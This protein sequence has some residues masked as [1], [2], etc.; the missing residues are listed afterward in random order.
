[1]SKSSRR[2]FLRR[3]SLGALGLAAADRLAPL[4][5]GAP[6]GVARAAGEKA[7]VVINLFGGNDG[8]NTV[9]PLGQYDRYRQMR[10]TLA[11]DRDELVALPGEPDFALNPGLAALA[12]LYA[13]GRL[14]LLN[15]VGVPPTATG[16]FDHA[17]QQFEFQSCDVVRAGGPGAPTGWLGRYLD[18]HVG[19]PVAPGIDMGGGRL[20]LTGSA[21]DPLSVNT[22][23]DLALRIS[24]DETARHDAYAAVQATPSANPVAERHRQ[25]RLQ[26]LDQSDRILAAVAGYSPRAAY[27]ADSSL[28]FY[29]QQCAKILWGDLGVR[30]LCVGLGGFDTHADQDDGRDAASL[31]YHAG[32][33]KDLADSMAAFQADVEAHGL[34]DRVLVLTVSEFGRTPFENG[35]AGSDHGF[36][37]VAFA[38]GSAVNGGVYG[39]YPG[40]GDDDLVLDGNVDVTT[41]FRSVYATAVGNFLGADPV[42]AV[43]GS[44]P[45]LG[46]V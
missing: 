32:L 4:V 1:M 26:A 27:P 2:S 35:S 40:L 12:P 31:G 11:Y 34:A 9:V 5:S 37:S 39:T 8:L 36:G 38:L 23:E 16:L 22:I 43:G 46:Y 17:A 14:A 15:G 18:A 41:D 33:L 21:C 42:P 24:F 44:F 25:V 7:V 19:G 30:G 20:M 45:L 29:L 10:P 13:Q 3:A 28:A 6:S